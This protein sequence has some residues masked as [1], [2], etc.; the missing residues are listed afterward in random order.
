MREV[1]TRATVASSLAAGAAEGF[2]AL[3]RPAPL[4]GGDIGA[5]PRRDRAAARRPRRGNASDGGGRAPARAARSHRRPRPRR[6]SR[7][8]P[9]RDAGAPRRGGHR[10]AGESTLDQAMVDRA[11]AAGAEVHHGDALDFLM[12][13]EDASFGAIFSSQLVEHLPANRLAELL[14]IARA[15]LVPGGVFVAETVNPHSPGTLK[16][17][18]VDPTH[19]HPLVPRVD[20]R[21]V[22]A[23][24]FRGG[25][26]HVPAGERR[27]RGRPADLRRVRGDR[28][29]GRRALISRRRGSGPARGERDRD[30]VDQH[31][32]RR[33]G[34]AASAARRDR[35]G[36]LAAVRAGRQRG[37]PS[38]GR[39]ALG[40]PDAG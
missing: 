3:S 5:G 12:K 30:R 33:F 32:H 1:D 19:Q 4:S 24:R 14:E 18:W 29:S 28:R 17:F 21:T 2:A 13:A 10:G 6:R 15:K 20:A 31:G 27:R 37:E 35:V 26:D 36:H 16:A 11:R 7:V 34:D 39:G 22:P 9:R 40:R 23:D 38:G 8:R 25:Q